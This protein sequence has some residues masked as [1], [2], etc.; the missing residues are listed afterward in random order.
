MLPEGAPGRCCPT[1]RQVAKRGTASKPAGATLPQ[2]LPAAPRGITRLKRIEKHDAT[3]DRRVQ[4]VDR[5][6]HWDRKRRN[7]TSP[8]PTGLTPLALVA[9]RR[10]PEDRLRSASVSEIA[11]GPRSK[12]T[13]Q[14]FDFLRRSIVRLTL[15][16]RATGNVLH[17]PG[18]SVAD[19]W[20]DTRGPS[21]RQND[22]I[23]AER[24][25]ASKKRPQISRVF[26]MVPAPAAGGPLCDPARSS[27]SSSSA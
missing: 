3:R 1:W 24:L 11:S 19:G 27:M 8:A 9:D 14:I 10:Q 23:H 12:P 13:V 22:P 20:R 7:H 5:T 26:Q 4:T 18:R 16:T 21:F 6:C 2:S 15:P 17:R 25:A